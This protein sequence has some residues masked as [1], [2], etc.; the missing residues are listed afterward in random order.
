M[1]PPQLYQA[2]AGIATS[3][4]RDMAMFA[5]GL[6]RARRAP[7]WTYLVGAGPSFAGSVTLGV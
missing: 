1:H 3:L 4:A 7:E 5:T 2:V 6:Y